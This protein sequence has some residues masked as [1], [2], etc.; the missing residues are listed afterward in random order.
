MLFEIT[1]AL[2]LQ[3]LALVYVHLTYRYRYWLRQGVTQVKPS[4]V[5]GNLGPLLRMQCT[6]AHM[7]QAMYNYPDACDQPF[8]GFYL[9]H[10]PAL[11]L[12][13]PE[14]IK[15]IL[16]KDFPKF[17]NR[18]SNSDY[19]GDPLGSLQEVGLN[20]NEYLL[21][22]PLNDSNCFQVELK[23]LC[24]LYTT[25]VIATV[26]FGIQ[27]NSFTYPN[28]EFRRHG[29]EIFRF[30]ASRALNFVAQAA[31][32]F[33]AGYETTSV[34]MSFALYE[35]AKNPSMQ[36]RV[37]KEICDAL[38]QSR[39]QIT[40]QIID[41]LEYMQ[42]I[43]DETL[44]LY[45]PLPFLDRECSLPKGQTYSLEPFHSFSL[46]SGMP[47]YIPVYAL[48]MDPKHFPQ[49]HKFQ[50][51][52]FSPE[53]KK[54]MTPYTYMPFGLGPHACI[55]ERFAMLQTKVGLFNFLRNHR[56]AMGEKSAKSIKLEPKALILQS[57]GGIHHVFFG[58]ARRQFC[59][60]GEDVVDDNQY[61]IFRYSCRNL[62]LQPNNINKCLGHS[63]ASYLGERKIRRVLICIP[64]AQ[65]PT[66]SE[67]K[68]LFRCKTSSFF[69]TLRS[70][71]RVPVPP[72]GPKQGEKSD[73]NVENFLENIVTL[74]TLTSFGKKKTTPHSKERHK[75]NEK[76][77]LVC[78]RNSPL[79]FFKLFALIPKAIVAMESV[80][81]QSR[82][83]R[84]FCISDILD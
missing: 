21:K 25:D 48:H 82:S 57:Q 65:Y 49:P 50:P 43:I 60:A 70:R 12:R 56:V 46:P 68:Q 23:E 16:C 39:G 29:R 71:W 55:G 30:S 59:L 69:H 18:F 54:L 81:Y 32:F 73:Q 61:D 1:L 34:T 36:E 9:F 78:V 7:I 62:Y 45:P 8:V 28:G 47:I 11:L 76:N 4:L 31:I 66:Q 37:R 33:I 84:E 19:F 2:L 10:R 24:A 79:E 44:R 13:D 22:M 15:R 14:L 77:D 35:M 72:H 52:R 63:L 38:S 58:R 41:N 27:A 20:L 51:E 67:A 75:S 64:S 42:M 5:V 53:C 74:K 17:C 26:A 6:S 3:V 40:Q 80:K 83:I